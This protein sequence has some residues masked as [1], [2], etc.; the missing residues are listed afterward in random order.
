MP[1]VRRVRCGGG[2]P[3]GARALLL[4]GALAGCTDSQPTE[5]Q[6]TFWAFGRE[7]EVVQQLVREFE[8]QAPGIR[9]R[10]QQI[11]WLAAH[12]KLL[13]AFAGEGGRVT[14]KD[15]DFL[16]SPVVGAAL[17]DYLAA[18]SA[19]DEADWCLK[20]TASNARR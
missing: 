1:H 4:V 17:P 11:P 16:L 18:V 2:L 6:L 15:A 9:V 20:L 5:T 10:V 13:T 7:G 19:G 3:A 14:K 12:E 8:A